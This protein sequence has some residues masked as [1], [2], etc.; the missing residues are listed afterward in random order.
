ME[1]TVGAS[2][3]FGPV[4]MDTMEKSPPIHIGLCVSGTDISQLPAAA[5]SPGVRQGSVMQGTQLRSS[6]VLQPHIF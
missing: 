1:V 3:E 4:T 6:G 5:K 2:I